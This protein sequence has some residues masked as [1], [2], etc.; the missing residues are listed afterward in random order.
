MT[1]V[2]GTTL[3][4]L[5]GLG[6]CAAPAMAAGTGYGGTSGT[7]STSGST[8]S[9]CATGT[10]ASADTVGSTGG[11]VTAQVGADTVTVTVP[12]GTLPAGS[13]VVITDNSSSE[14]SPASGYTVV[15]A[16]SISVCLNGAKYTGTFSPVAVSVTGANIISGARIF[17]L[18]G[19]TYGPLSGA[20]VSV[21]SITYSITSDPAYEVAVP[22]TAVASTAIPNATVVVTGKPFLLEGLIA[23]LLFA[24]GTLLL[25][26]L[27]IRR[28]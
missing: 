1:R 11:T 5:V 13:Q 3:V 21:G 24:T 8:G 22:S 16:Y 4:A 23:L 25:I 7:G 10:V 28:S 6:L 12:A 15:L 9:G 27:R 19:A 14:T 18:T 17:V 26:R 20:T 2:V